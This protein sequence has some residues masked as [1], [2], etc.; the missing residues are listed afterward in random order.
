MSVLIS[1]ATDDA[2]EESVTQLE[3]KWQRNLDWK[4]GNG[5]FQTMPFHQRWVQQVR[6]SM[7]VSTQTCIWTGG[8]PHWKWMSGTERQARAQTTPTNP[9]TA[10]HQQPTSITNTTNDNTN[11]DHHTSHNNNTMNLN[12]KVTDTTKINNN[13]SNRMDEGL[14]EHNSC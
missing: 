9:P 13:N 11:N 10:E 1:S 2:G 7:R 14:G 6:W 4:K 3:L 5:S 8:P 12:I